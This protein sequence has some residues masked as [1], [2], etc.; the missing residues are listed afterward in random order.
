MVNFEQVNVSWVICFHLRLAFYY[1]YQDLISSLKTITKISQK[2]KLKQ[3]SKNNPERV[4]TAQNSWRNP[5]EKTFTYHRLL[6]QTTT[7]LN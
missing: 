2:Q 1:D 4:K 6:L 7:L 3:K 5:M